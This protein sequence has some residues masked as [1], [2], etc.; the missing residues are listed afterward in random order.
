LYTEKRNAIIDFSLSDAFV[1]AFTILVSQ[2][3]S[4]DDVDSYKNGPQN[5]FLTSRGIN[6]LV[7]MVVNFIG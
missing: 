2:V 1:D 3:I 5:D 4:I 7:G 6:H